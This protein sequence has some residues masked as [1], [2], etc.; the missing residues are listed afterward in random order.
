MLD[1]LDGVVLAVRLMNVGFFLGFIDRRGVVVQPEFLDHLGQQ[2]HR[3]HLAF[4]AQVVIAGVVPA[5]AVEIRHAVARFILGQRV[6]SLVIPVEMVA[7][8]RH[9]RVILVVQAVPGAVLFLDQH[10]AHLD[11]QEVFQRR[12]PDVAVEDVVA[13]LKRVRDLVAIAQHVHAGGRHGAEVGG[14]IVVAQEMPPRFGS[15]TLHLLAARRRHA[16]QHQRIGLGIAHVL[17]DDDRLGLA[18][19]ISDLR[20]LHDGLVTPVRI[21]IGRDDP[22][23]GIFRGAR[24]GDLAH[25]IPGVIEGAA[26]VEQLQLTGLA[27]DRHALQIAVGRDDQ[28]MA[29]GHRCG[30]DLAVIVLHRAIGLT[31]EQAGL[32]VHQPRLAEQLTGE[33][34]EIEAD[35]AFPI[36]WQRFVE[37][38]RNLKGVAVQ[39]RDADMIAEIEVG[40]VDRIETLAILAVIRIVQRLA[41]CIAGGV[42]DSLAVAGRHGRPLPGRRLQAQVAVG[43]DTRS[44]L[45]DGDAGL[46]TVRIDIG[47]DCD[48]EPRRLEIALVVELERRLGRCGAGHQTQGRTGR[49][50][51]FENTLRHLSLPKI[52]GRG[53]AT[54]CNRFQVA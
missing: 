32:I 38:D 4:D 23:N 29:L 35:L 33:Q 25:H 17:L 30:D 16:I 49:H 54:H 8:L 13:D 47:E 22:G 34:L 6:R 27:L 7:D 39:R 43:G 10:V 2:P 52:G 18:R 1:L 48:I 19:A 20:H 12:L 44:V 36:L 31:G 28:P 3:A 5:A 45:D 41:D 37:I 11:G 14:H 24:L 26:A 9:A 51:A 40:I 46:V 15:E 53:P 42:D 50:Q 21:D